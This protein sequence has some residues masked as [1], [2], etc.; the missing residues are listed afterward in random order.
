MCDR[1]A[2]L[3]PERDATHRACDQRRHVRHR[4]RF[5][6]AGALHNAGKRADREQHV[7]I[8]AA[9]GDQA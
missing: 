7:L 1:G 8:E 5:G 2:E 6:I 3:A 4:V 9:Y